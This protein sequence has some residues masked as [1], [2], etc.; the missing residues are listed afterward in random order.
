MDPVMQEILRKS[1]EM[2]VEDPLQLLDS[3][4]L[5]FSKKEVKL[6]NKTG[7]KLEIKMMD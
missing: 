4:F 7:E 2:T 5:D 3:I 1:I 6:I